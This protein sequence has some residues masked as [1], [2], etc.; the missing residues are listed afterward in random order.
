MVV[1]KSSEHVEEHLKWMLVVVSK[2][3]A[4]CMVCRFTKLF[5]HS[6]KYSVKTQMVC[7]QNA[8][9][10]MDNYTSQLTIKNTKAIHKR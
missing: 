7:I 3:N 6:G 1:P 4:L 10:K 2:Y 5:G 9:I 8:C